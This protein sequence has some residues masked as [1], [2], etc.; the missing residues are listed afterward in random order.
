[1]GKVKYTFDCVKNY[2]DFAES[3]LY[4][5]GEKVAELTDGNGNAVI[6]DIHG[7]KRIHYNHEV[8][9]YTQDFP[10]ELIKILQDGTVD[11]HPEVEII[12]NNWL[13]ISYYYYCQTPLNTIGFIDD[14]VFEEDLAKMSRKELKKYLIETL[15]AF[16]DMYSD[17]EDED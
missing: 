9:R 4:D 13:D 14:M 1:M 11:E 3:L 10:D 15:E 12:D 8:Y 5:A 6:L 7:E 16:K 2:K 17:E